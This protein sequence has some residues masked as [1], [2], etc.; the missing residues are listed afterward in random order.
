[1]IATWARAATACTLG[2]SLAMCL[3]FPQKQNR[4]YY[5]GD[6]CCSWGGQLPIF[7][8]FP[9]QIGSGYQALRYLALDWVSGFLNGFG[10]GPSGQLCL[11]GGF[12]WVILAFH[13]QV[14]GVMACMRFSEILT[15]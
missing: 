10:F 1:M 4:G 7:P 8:E 13:S 14:L 11:I 6:V 12:S 15:K 2:H 9:G 5:P 3:V